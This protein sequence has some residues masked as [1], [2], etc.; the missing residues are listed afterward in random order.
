VKH[1]NHIEELL[2]KI[3]NHLQFTE[4]LKHWRKYYQ[5]K[6]KDIDE[7][8]IDTMLGYCCLHPHYK[9]PNDEPTIDHS[10]IKGMVAVLK[11]YYSYRAKNKC[12]E[13]N[14]IYKCYDIGK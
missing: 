11:E 10:W 1:D 4:F 5:Q 7:H 9:C 12:G 2:G 8:Y 14:C 3:K 6:E 13:L